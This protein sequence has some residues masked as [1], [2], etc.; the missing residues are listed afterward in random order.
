MTARGRN[1]VRP[2]GF[3]CRLCDQVTYAFQEIIKNARCSSSA[4]R[5]LFCIID[6]VKKKDRAGVLRP[7]SVI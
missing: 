1:A 3:C 7:V 5:I 6:I 2:Y 4:T